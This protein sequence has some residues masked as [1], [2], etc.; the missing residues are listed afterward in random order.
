MKISSGYSP[1]AFWLSFKGSCSVPLMASPL[2]IAWSLLL[3]MGQQGI[4]MLYTPRAH[5][6]PSELSLRILESPAQMA[7]SPHAG[8]VHVSL[9]G[10]ASQGWLVPTMCRP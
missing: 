4:K 5:V 7:P 8:P 3:P 9:W 1:E 10:P 2:H 6:F